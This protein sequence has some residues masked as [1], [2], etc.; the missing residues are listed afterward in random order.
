[1]ALTED[2]AARMIRVEDNVQKLHS[3]VTDVRVAVATLTAEVAAHD[4]RDTDRHDDLKAEFGTLKTDMGTFRTQLDTLRTDVSRTVD[5]AVDRV[6]TQTRDA[7]AAARAEEQ[8]TTRQRFE[9]IGK[10][11]VALFSLVATIA[12]IV[13]GLSPAEV[14]QKAATIAPAP[15][16]PA[17]D[18]TTPPA[19]TPTQT[20]PTP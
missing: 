10:I 11:T 4:K 9:L 18:A 8:A 15:T 12:G 13:Y 6:A 3:E 5:T 19:T 14:A 1:M 16:A 20:A 7:I 2:L 17:T